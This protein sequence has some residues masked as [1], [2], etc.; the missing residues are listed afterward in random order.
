MDAA[1][2]RAEFP[3]LERVAY[4]NTGT[5]GPV[6][7]RGTRT[8]A[9]Q[10][11][12]ELERGRGNQAHFAA[13]VELQTAIRGRLAGLLGCAAEEVAVTRST[14]DG[15][16]TVLSALELPPDCEVVTSDEE[17]PGLLAPLAAA[18]RRRGFAVRTVPFAD[19]AAAA[20][21]R[22]R[23]VACSHVSW[24]SGRIVDAAALA[25]TPALVLLDGAQG[26]G[27]VEVDVRA[28]GCDF[29]AAAGQKW[30]CGPDGSG[31]LYVR[32]DRV[33]DLPAPWPGYV[34]LADPAEPLELRL[35][36]GAPRFDLGLL[37][38]P[39]A[40]WWLSALELLDE[41]RAAW[42]VERGTGLAARLAGELA[43]RGLE[44]VPR[45]ASTLV[46]WRS[47]DPEAA[48]ERLASEGF[49]VRQL[50]GRGLVRASVGAWSSE[51]ELERLAAAAVSSG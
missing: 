38:G 6:P 10:V 5:H 1:A 22:T 48:V 45:G 43:E 42:V 2:F 30:L 44:V 7:R 11:E 29:Y 12:R 33:D 49:V 21:P 23:L 19:V 8:A 15:I 24:I 16:A 41:A 25:A 40:A 46:S 3:V 13:L 28:L 26:L 50:P 47:D 34:S 31:C 36:D 18:A 27:A 17:H 9:E 35:R 14:T 20:G 39:L 32:A 4:L 51:E 37:P